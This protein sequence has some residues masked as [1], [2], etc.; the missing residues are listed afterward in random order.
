MVSQ[1]DQIRYKIPN[2]VPVSSKEWMNV[3]ELVEKVEAICII[4]IQMY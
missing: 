2:S 4:P 3:D 1:A